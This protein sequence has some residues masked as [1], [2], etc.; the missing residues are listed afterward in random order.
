MVNFGQSTNLQKWFKNMQ[1]LP[2]RKIPHYLPQQGE[3]AKQKK[4]NSFD[5]SSHKQTPPFQLQRDA[6]GKLRNNQ[7]AI[8]EQ[9]RNNSLDYSRY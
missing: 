2:F 5:M 4:R 8:N 7:E 9:Y 6:T 3:L 1:P